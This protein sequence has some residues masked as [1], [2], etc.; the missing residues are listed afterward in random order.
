MKIIT[1]VIML[2]NKINTVMS[3]TLKN[4]MIR[5]SKTKLNTFKKMLEDG[6]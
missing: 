4:I 5:M 1:I 6:C 2:I 3:Q